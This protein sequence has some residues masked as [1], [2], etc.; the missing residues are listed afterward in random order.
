MVISDGKICVIRFAGFDG[1][2]H[3]LPVGIFCHEPL[4]LS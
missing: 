1:D 4:V 3:D 2:Q